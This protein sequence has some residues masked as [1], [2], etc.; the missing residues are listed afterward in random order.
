[1]YKPELETPVAGGTVVGRVSR[2]GG[3]GVTGRQEWAWSGE[4]GE[5]T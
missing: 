4:M 3:T 1:M 2:W 5:P